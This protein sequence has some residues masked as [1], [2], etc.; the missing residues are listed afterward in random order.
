MS[1]NPELLNLL[2]VAYQMAGGT[3]DVAAI[4]N[5]RQSGAIARLLTRMAAFAETRNLGVVYGPGTM[6]QI[7]G[8]TYYPHISFIP[9]ASIPAAGEPETAWT[10]A[11]QLVAEVIPAAEIS[12]DTQMLMAAYFAAGV[13]QVWI[14]LL[15]SRKVFLYRSMADFVELYE[16][17]D[18]L[19][20]E[21]LPGFR[22]RVAE[23]FAFTPRANKS[24]EKSRA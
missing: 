21:V 12:K 1:A 20:L 5:A 11:P 18:L 8:Q 24:A 7:D 4:D 6:Y 15:E 9:A 22:C 2:G 13:R 19:N 16:T 23:I 3:L 10:I 14:A 17:E